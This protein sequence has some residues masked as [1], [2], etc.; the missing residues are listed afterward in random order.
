MKVYKIRHKPTGLF[1]IPSRGNGNLS[2]TGKIYQRKPDIK[3]T[4]MIRI[5]VRTNSIDKLTKKQKTIID[6]FKLDPASNNKY[7]WVDKHFKT[8]PSD[9]EIIEY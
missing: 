7:Y 3:Y 9:W 5:I 2:T 6:Y 8:D 1:Y 4:S